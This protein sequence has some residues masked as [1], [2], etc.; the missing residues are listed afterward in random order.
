[1]CATARSMADDSE[2]PPRRRPQF[3]VVHKPRVAVRKQ[4]ST[5]SSLAGT[6]VTGETIDAESVE[7]GWIKL[8]DG[9]GFMLIDGQSVGLG[10]L[11]EA[12]PVPDTSITLNFARPDNGK[13]ML[14]LT[15]PWNTTIAK[16]K[17][18][19]AEATKLRVGSMVLARGKSAHCLP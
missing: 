9:A 13:H 17:A 5:D 10:L 3:K 15:L 1:M 12:V 4:P 19:V 7:N 18:A 8:P 2:L 11:L 14:A 16:T 6:K